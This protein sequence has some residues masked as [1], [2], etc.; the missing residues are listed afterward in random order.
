MKTLTT[1]TAALLIVLSFSAFTTEDQNSEKLKMNYAVQ[2]YI[3][4]VT[5]G[6]LKGFSEVIDN[7]ANFTMTKG[8]S[9]VNHSK[10]EILNAMKSTKGIQQN[11]STD[12]SVIEQT[13]NQAIVKITQ[14]YDSFSRINF[15]TA[16][17]TSK[18]WKI[19]NVSSSFQ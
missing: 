15:V 14:K 12:F 11:C 6:Q 10:S 19:T 16:A 4:A 13:P 9:I 3:D 5:N 17:N 18:G 8:S 2:T 7:S 1:L